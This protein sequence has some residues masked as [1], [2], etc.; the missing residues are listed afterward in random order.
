MKSMLYTK[1]QALV[2]LL[3]TITVVVYRPINN[4]YIK[5]LRDQ[6]LPKEL[7]NFE[8]GKYYAQCS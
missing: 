3:V 2:N 1:P 5:Y 7:Q 6:G 4:L 8:P